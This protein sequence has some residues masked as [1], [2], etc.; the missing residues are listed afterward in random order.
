MVSAQRWAVVCGLVRRP[1]LALAKLRKLADWT[2]AG[3]LDGVVISWWQEEGFRH[4]AVAEAIRDYGFTVVQTHEPRLKMI[5]HYI[6]QC[7]SLS[8][9]LQA[10]PAG[11]MVLK[12][13][14]DLHPLS[15]AMRRRLETVDL[16][17]APQPG[18]PQPF[19]RKILAPWAFATAPFYIG[20][21]AIFG[22]REDLLKLAAFDVSPE[23][24][25]SHFQTEQF[26]YS[27]PFR[28]HFPLLREY[29]IFLP[30]F[31]YDQPQE[32]GRILDCLLAADYYLDVLACHLLMV[33]HY[34]QLGMEAEGPAPAV[35]EREMDLRALLAGQARAPDI[36]LLPGPHAVLF[37]GDRPITALAAGRV[38]MDDL[39]RR[40]AMAL[41]R[42]RDYGYQARFEANPLRL[43]LGAEALKRSLDSFPE[44][45]PR[46]GERDPQ[47]GSFVI[48]GHDDRVLFLGGSDE[49]LELRA[50]IA[51]LRRQID[52]LRQAGVAFGEGRL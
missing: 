20:D 8:Y 41:E 44:A 6:H 3:F 40:F 5:G 4:P 25:F 2:Q 22:L 7:K 17:L 33:N 29:S 39:G 42:V 48:A 30:P 50:E 27:S 18:W 24:L 38:K 11:A 16:A 14:F 19:K 9:G 52:G 47:T 51:D 21:V 12:T 28:N 36:A 49:V 1:D 23:Y 15:E 26:I 43:S 10:T 32:S 45:A 31:I 46:T 37:K 34:F 13:R 35:E